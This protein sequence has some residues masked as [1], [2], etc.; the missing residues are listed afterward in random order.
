MNN[1][2]KLIELFIYIVIV[3][4]GIVLLLTGGADDKTYAV[5]LDE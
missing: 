2:N 4:V 3:I 5:I 1:R